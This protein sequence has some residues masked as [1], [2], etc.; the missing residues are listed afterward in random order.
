MK[1]NLLAFISL[2]LSV[3]MI[4]ASCAAWENKT[5]EETENTLRIENS[6]ESTVASDDYKIKELDIDILNDQNNK[7][8][9]TFS[10][11]DFIES[12]N[13][14]YYEKRNNYFLRDSADWDLFNYEET[15]HFA[16]PS[17]YYRFQQDVNNFNEPTISVYVPENGEY[18]QEITLDY[19][20]H[21][22]TEWGYEMF[23]EYCFYALKTFFPNFDD[24]QIKKMYNTIFDK[25]YDSDCFFS[26][27]ERPSPKMLY[28]KDNIGI[29][30]YFRV[31]MFFIAVIPVTQQYINELKLNNV[32]IY[33]IDDLI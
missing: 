33:E 28:H 14:Y 8:V 16:S 20:D 24:E 21:N 2:M 12:F 6:T 11:D 25:A 10:I 23:E 26:S 19:P 9:F 15:P 3:S 7:P 27:T 32:D 18:V 5:E 30:P 1:R 13:G 29:Y 22:Y 31:G 17:L 4:F